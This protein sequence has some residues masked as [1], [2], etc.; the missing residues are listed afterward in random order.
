MFE[1]D[2][3]KN[4]ANIAKHGV[5][6]ALAKQ[7]FEGPILTG[8]DGRDYFGELREVSIGLA[9]GVVLLTVVHTDRAGITRLISARRATKREREA[10]GEA[11]RKGLI[12]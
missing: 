8:F 11:L 4:R 12:G 10:Y 3:A 7:I 1:W 6:F 5:D 9:G 2:E